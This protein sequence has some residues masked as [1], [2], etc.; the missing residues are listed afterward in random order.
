MTRRTADAT[1]LPQ[2]LAEAHL[3][4]FG[5]GVDGEPARPQNSCVRSTATA[6]SSIKLRTVG[7]E[8]LD[9]YLVS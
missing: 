9:L 5:G 7:D 1:F 4:S 8:D 6:T 3:E 2:C